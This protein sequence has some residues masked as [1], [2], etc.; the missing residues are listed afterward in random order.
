[1]NQGFLDLTLHYYPQQKY[2]Y[3]G[4]QM[5]PI[6]GGNTRWKIYSQM[7]E[8]SLLKISSPFF[9]CFG[10]DKNNLYMKLLQLYDTLY[11]MQCIANITYLQNFIYCFKIFCTNWLGKIQRDCVYIWNIKPNIHKFHWDYIMERKFLQTDLISWEISFLWKILRFY[12]YICF[13]FNLSM[14]YNAKV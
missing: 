8:S 5:F 1:M 2:K 3:I 12:F 10:F 13:Y 9:C 6:K 14:I 11:Y 4:L 7:F